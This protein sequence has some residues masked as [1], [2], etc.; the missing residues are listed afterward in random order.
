[1]KDILC[2]FIE[3]SN[4]F[5]ACQEVIKKMSLALDESKQLALR[6]NSHT[7]FEHIPQVERNY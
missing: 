6:T 3:G 7:P 4:S 5:L 2:Q 1:M